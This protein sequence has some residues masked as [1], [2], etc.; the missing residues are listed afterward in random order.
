MWVCVRAKERTRTHYKLCGI[1]GCNSVRRCSGGQELVKSHLPG[2]VEEWSK[3]ECLQTQEFPE[4]AAK[5]T[6]VVHP[7]G[8]PADSRLPVTLGSPDSQS[9][10]SEEGVR[11]QGKT[12]RQRETE[13]SYLLVHST[14][15]HLCHA[16][17]TLKPGEVRSF[18][19]GSQGG[20]QHPS[21]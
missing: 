13:I 3:P 6:S 14:D 5:E 9:A 18:I 1:Q 19:W 16:W 21:S 17:I 12:E 10:A 15:G 11:I 20:W 7:E 4:P 8:V 2:E